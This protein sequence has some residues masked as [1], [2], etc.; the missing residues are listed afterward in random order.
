MY[1]ISIRRS[2]TERY[3]F[4]NGVASLEENDAP[5]S[6]EALAPA[7][8][9]CSGAARCARLRCK[10]TGVDVQMWL[11][12]SSERIIS[13]SFHDIC[14]L[15]SSELWVNQ[16]RRSGPCGTDESRTHLHEMSRRSGYNVCFGWSHGGVGEAA[17]AP[18]IQPHA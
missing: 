2:I 1:D 5:Q 8:P 15:N 4:W 6:Q 7:V 13:P 14:L 12:S 9:P 17:P 3:H 16:Y 11:Y 10:Q 18:V